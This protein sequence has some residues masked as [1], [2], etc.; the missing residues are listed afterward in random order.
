MYTREI[1]CILGE[2]YVYR[3]ILYT[4]TIMT[5]KSITVLPYTTNIG[6]E[7]YNNILIKGNNGYYYYHYYYYY[8]YYCFYYHY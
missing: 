4:I 3:G 8:C 7:G 6:N 5:G 2:Y 1:L